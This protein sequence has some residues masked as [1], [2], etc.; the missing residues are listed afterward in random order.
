MIIGL[1]AFGDTVAFDTFNIVNNFYRLELMNMKADEISIK[2][3]I[4]L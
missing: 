3:Q 2:E 1:D 4:I